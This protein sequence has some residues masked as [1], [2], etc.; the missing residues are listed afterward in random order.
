MV[1]SPSLRG[2]HGFADQRKPRDETE[3]CP[4]TADERRSYRRR[5][6]N[7]SSHTAVVGVST[8]T[9]AARRAFEI[10]LGMATLAAL[11]GAWLTFFS[12][13]P[14]DLRVH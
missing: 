3:A 14:L 8:P 11:T 6:T 13:V 7:I 1:R 12:V 5:M 2:A 10:A 4:V 9:D